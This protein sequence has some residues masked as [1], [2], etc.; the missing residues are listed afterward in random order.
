M[1]IDN[2]SRTK[3]AVKGAA[4]SSLINVISKLEKNMN[5]QL[6]KANK[7][8]NS[9][10]YMRVPSADSLNELPIYASERP[11]PLERLAALDNC[12]IG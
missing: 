6:E 1:G 7:E 8:N 4:S 10:Y 12:S 11:R 5:S 2:L 3:R 9:I